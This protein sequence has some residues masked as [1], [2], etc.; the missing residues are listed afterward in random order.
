MKIL[1]VPRKFH[2]LSHKESTYLNN[3]F[4]SIG[5]RPNEEGVPVKYDGDNVLRLIF[6]DIT[7]SQSIYGDL[8]IIFSEKEAKKIHKFVDSMDLSKMLIVNCFAGISRS[9][10]VGD[11]LNIYLNI[12]KNHNKDDYQWFFE[13]N[14]QIQPNPL[15]S[16]ILMKELGLTYDK[17]E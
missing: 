13:N 10:A 12:F 8:G 3:Y 6:D 4:I 11:V 15:V 16:R 9:G 1:V 7:D 14:R 2:L 17:E 5:E